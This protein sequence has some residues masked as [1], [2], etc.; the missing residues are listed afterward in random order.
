[1]TRIPPIAC[2][3]AFLTA[4]LP[5]PARADRRAYA[6]TYEAVTAAP[7]Q[8]DVEAWHTYA[9]GGEISNGPP[10]K[11]NR[12]MLELEYGI[13]A[14]WDVA[15]YN[16]LDTGTEDDGY[17][18][19]KI[20]TRYR[21]ALPGTLFVDPVLYLEY[22]HLFR[23]DATDKFEIKGIFARNIGPWNLALNLAFELEREK[24]MDETE[25]KPEGEFAFGVS[26]ELGSPALKLGAEVFGFVEKEEVPGM[27]AEVEPYIFAGPA[28]SWA[29]GLH[30]ALSGL[31]LTVGAGRGIVE[32]DDYY[33]RVILGLQF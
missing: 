28:L 2:A 23:G 12:T 26:R 33:A 8:L 15:L 11:G 6:E 30:S 13:T 20:E 7:G 18:G 24:E 19:F 32:S 29:T 25:F 21:L 14:R 1:M 3:A 9:S 4:A 31:W 17:A 16:L 5:S 10:T 27:E 22:Q